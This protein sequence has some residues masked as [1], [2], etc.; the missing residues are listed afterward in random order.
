MRNEIKKT[1]QIS[2]THA[3][4]HP[5]IQTHVAFSIHQHFCWLHKVTAGSWEQKD[6]HGAIIVRNQRVHFT[7][8]AALHS[9]VK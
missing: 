5:H 9:M 1:D 7:E 3:H 2:H 4:T 6:Q 8:K